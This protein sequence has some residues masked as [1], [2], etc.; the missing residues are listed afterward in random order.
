ME[1]REE[2]GYI[3]ICI[4]ITVLVIIFAIV[5]LIMAINEA[6]IK[7]KDEKVLQSAK[8]EES[9]QNKNEEVK[10]AEEKIINLEDNEYM[11]VEIDSSGDKV[12]VPRGYVG[13]SVASENEIDT[14]YV[15]YE[16]EEP[17][18]QENVEVAQTTRNQFVWVPVPDSSQMYGT[19]SK[20][21][22]WG[23]LYNFN[24]S[25]GAVTNNNWSESNGVMRISSSTGYREPDILK[26]YDKDSQ[27]KTY[28]IGVKSMNEF[29]MDLQ[30]EF[31]SMIK[32]VEKY[33]GFYIGRYETGNLSQNIPVVVKGNTD[34]SNQ[35]WYKMYDGCKRIS[36]G[37]QKVKTGIIWGCQW[38]ATL[39]WFQ[40]SSDENVVK[41]VIDRTMEASNA[42]NRVGRRWQLLW[43]FG[44]RQSCFLP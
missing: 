33:G 40:T 43:Q 44:F 2:K 17:V 14:G 19:D 25:T 39:K 30:K 1:K 29:Y 23:K 36:G 16:G 8:I 26:N 27:L 12:P 10:K 42:N 38:D 18:T 4:G 35:N 31:N 20:G 32:S 37:N 21:K 41:Y 3:K 15:I 24:K 9:K 22:K 5:V 7:N 34:I 28:G 11:H 13:S 6:G